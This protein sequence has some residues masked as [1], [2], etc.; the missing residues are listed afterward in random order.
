MA[1][2]PEQVRSV[3]PWSENRFSNNYNIRSRILTGGKNT[4]VFLDSFK[5]TK[6]SDTKI[7]IGPGVAIKDDVMVHIME[8]V[9]INLIADEGYV[10][11]GEGEP[12]IPAPDVDIILHVCLNYHYFRSIPA[13][14][15]RYVIIK[16]PTAHFKVADHLWLGRIHV[17]NNKIVEVTT[18]P[19]RLPNEE[20]GTVFSRSCIDPLMGYTTFNGGVIRT[21]HPE[22][23]PQ[24]YQWFENWDF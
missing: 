23:D 20:G 14:D 5:I 6:L 24:N 4:V 1:I 21:E 22:E 2:I 9:T 18:E 17:V 13:P 19:I 10:L 12:P 8:D 3:D 16:Y 11:S 7:K 15:A